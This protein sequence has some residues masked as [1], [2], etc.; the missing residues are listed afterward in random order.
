M[1]IRKVKVEWDN[2]H[3]MSAYQ[4][5]DE[6][7][8]YFIKNKI[9][10]KLFIIRTISKKMIKNGGIEVLNQKLSINGIEF[11]VGTPAL[12]PMPTWRILTEFCIYCANRG[13]RGVKNG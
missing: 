11:F 1:Q 12:C 7:E 3:Y 8:E 10:T 4:L 6:T 5:F 2:K 13:L 9:N